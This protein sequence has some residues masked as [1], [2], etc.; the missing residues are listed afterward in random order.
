[1][2]LGLEFPPVS[3]LVEWP[4]FWLEDTGFGVNKV[5]ILMW[6]SALIAFGGASGLSVPLLLLVV[7]AFRRLPPA[8]GPF[9]SSMVVVALAGES[10]G[11]FERYA[12][13]AF[14]LVMA[15][16]F[17]LAR[18]LFGFHLAQ[19]HELLPVASLL[20]HLAQRN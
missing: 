18:E 6:L 1:M 2:I 10:L 16:A 20:V 19:T 8:Y 12:L 5:V 14:P 15:G 17:L 4:Q 7:V 11:S 13:S 9:A 3:H